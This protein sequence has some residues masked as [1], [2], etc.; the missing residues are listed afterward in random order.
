MIVR[1]KPPF[2]VSLVFLPFWRFFHPHHALG[3]GGAAACIEAITLFS[4]SRDNF[5]LLGYIPRVMTQLG[6]A[7]LHGCHLL[8]L[9]LAFRRFEGFFVSVALPR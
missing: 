5:W 6:G 8:V 2:Q 4:P 7:R 3:C 9:I 1:L